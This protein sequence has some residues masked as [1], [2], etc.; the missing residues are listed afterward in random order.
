[1]AMPLLGQS[2]PA[3]SPVAAGDPGGLA[4]AQ[5]EQGPIGPQGP[6]GPQ[7]PPGQ[8]GSNASVTAGDGIAVANGQISLNPAFT[9][10]LYWKQGGN[11]GIDPATNFLGTTDLQPLDIRV[12][13][14]SALRIQWIEHDNPD[15]ANET[16]RAPNTL[17]GYEGNSLGPGTTGATIF[18]GW[19]FTDNNGMVHTLPNMVS[20][21]FSTISGGYMNAI[22]SHRNAFNQTVGQASAIAG[23]FFNTTDENAAFIGAGNNNV[24]E[25][26]GSVIGGGDTNHVTGGLGAIGGGASNVADI[27]ATVAGGQNG[28][29]T[30]EFSAIG[31][32]NNNTASG[33]GSAIV[34]GYNNSASGSA[35]TVCGGS[36]NAADGH[37]SCAMGH[38]AHAA[39]DGSFVWSDPGVHQSA[40]YTSTFANN[41][42]LITTSGGTS[43]QRTDPLN[44]VNTVTTNAALMVEKLNGGGEALWLWQRLAEATAPVVKLHR[45]PNGT[46][47]F[48]QGFDW[49]GPGLTP[50]LTE[51]WHI[52]A[53]GT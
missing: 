39:N 53:A 34:G 16:F 36:G 24:A 48:M 52:N 33:D 10:S 9:D 37:Y 31:G 32:G 3:G 51:K 25:G 18:G 46:N 38:Q 26:G 7:G 44:G 12:N 30:G 8:N 43:I 11:A 22:H 50:V 5:I 41:Q 28:H 40:S 45:N 17:G 23:G 29:A 21:D 1:M 4:D 20:A 2:C 13:N 42:F 27:L 6:A 35:A 19:E 47:D 15:L 49:I 14:R